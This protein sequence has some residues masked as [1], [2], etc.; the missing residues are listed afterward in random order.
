MSK[1]PSRVRIG[2][3]V[4]EVSTQK[5]KH[6]AD[7]SHWGFT[8]GQDATIVIDA[9]MPPALMRTTLVHE[10]LHAIRYV[11]GGSFN[12]GKGT[13]YEEWEHYWIGLYEEP[14][15]MVFRDNPELVEF[16]LADD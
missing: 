13:V 8:S 6:S 2:Q 3:T 1:L 12:P 10:I 9:E 16:L 15:V 11:F 5:R 14:L 4:Y 7:A